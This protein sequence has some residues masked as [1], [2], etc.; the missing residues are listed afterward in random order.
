VPVR[1]FYTRLNLVILASVSCDIICDY[2]RILCNLD[3]IGKLIICG[4]MSH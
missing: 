1:I 4:P 3:S 2:I